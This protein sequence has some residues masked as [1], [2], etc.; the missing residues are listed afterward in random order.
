M[1]TEEGILPLVQAAQYHEDWRW[2][3]NLLSSST[4]FQASLF[5]LAGLCALAL[6]VGYRTRLAVILSWMLVLSL[7]VRMPLVLNAG[8]A[9]LR[10]LLFW[11]MF[12][13]LGEAWS[14]DALRRPRSRAG[15]AGDVLL[16]AATVGIVLQVCIVY[17]YAGLAKLNQVWLGGDAMDHVLRYSMLVK[18]LGEYLLNYPDLLTWITKGTLLLEIG[19]P[20]LLFIPWKWVRAAAIAAFAAFHLGIELTLHVGQFAFVSLSAL[21]LFL[22]RAFWTNPFSAAIGS[23]MKSLLQGHVPELP[24]SVP[25][26]PS[27]PATGG[28]LE[29]WSRRT[30]NVMCPLFLVYLVGSWDFSTLRY[31]EMP[32]W[33]KPIGNVT[34]LPQAWGMYHTAIPRDHWYIYRATLRNGRMIDLLPAGSRPAG[35]HTGCNS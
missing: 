31:R 18:P 20:F 15:S 27:E 5:A 13:P 24:G 6:L 23:Q 10:L 19:G 22:P 29:K 30:S 12:L 7:H 34:M 21:T 32:A 2:S 3:L 1:Y 25:Q 16:S 33:L 14:L 9:Y 4:E 17:W 26:P 28:R 8:D 35:G 11:S